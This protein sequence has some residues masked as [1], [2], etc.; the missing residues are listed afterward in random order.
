MLIN[1]EVAYFIFY[2]T[3][4]NMGYID[5]V[6]PEGVVLP[7][8][9]RLHNAHHDYSLPYPHPVFDMAP[10]RDCLQSQQSKQ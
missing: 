2:E 6:T 7:V 1:A 4:P 3:F 8:R 5:Q 10:E 9:P